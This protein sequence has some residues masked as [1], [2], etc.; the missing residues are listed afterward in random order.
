MSGTKINWSIWEVPVGPEMVFPRRRI[1]R[2]PRDE[3]MEQYARLREETG[4]KGLVVTDQ[5][6]EAVYACS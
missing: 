1:F 6:G 4:D 3:T 5:D 2:A